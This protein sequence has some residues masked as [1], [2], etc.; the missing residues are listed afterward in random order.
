MR[1]TAGN[2]LVENRAKNGGP[3]LV[4]HPF[5]RTDSIMMKAATM[6]AVK[7]DDNLDGKDTVLD[8]TQ[9]NLPINC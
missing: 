5:V 1:N 8:K 3:N 7:N 6:D 2:R 4:S 9:N